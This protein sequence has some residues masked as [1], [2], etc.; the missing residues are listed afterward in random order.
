[1]SRASS[2]F[3]GTTS[4]ISLAT[5]GMQLIQG[6]YLDRY[7]P[8]FNRSIDYIYQSVSCDAHHPVTPNPFERD[9]FAIRCDWERVFGRASVRIR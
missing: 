6:D 1:M 7:A 5:A 8:N 2:F 9:R 4:V 3:H